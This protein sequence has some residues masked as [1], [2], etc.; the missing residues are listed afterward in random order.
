M[1]IWIFFK[2][3]KGTNLC[4]KRNRV[5]LFFNDFERNARQL[6]T[7]IIAHYEPDTLDVSSSCPSL[8]NLV[9]FCAQLDAC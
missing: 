7:Y 4:G 1:D 8:Q 9:D 5:G 2:L 3:T 6:S